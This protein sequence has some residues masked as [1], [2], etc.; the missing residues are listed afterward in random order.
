MGSKAR[1]LF[2]NVYLHRHCSP[3]SEQFE[4]NAKLQAFQDH[5]V[6]SYEPFEVFQHRRT[7]R[8]GGG[9]GGAAAPPPKF[10]QRY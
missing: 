9:A 3:T 5:T 4:A 6:P 2:F 10:S 8:G 7:G 1:W